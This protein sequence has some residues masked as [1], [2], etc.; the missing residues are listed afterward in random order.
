MMR[1]M[2]SE[3]LALTTQEAVAHLQGRWT[4][5]IAAYDTVRAEILDTAH[6][7]A[8]GIIAQFPARLR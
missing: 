2:I 3:H 1:A 5:D 7:L 6:G 4:A 8:D